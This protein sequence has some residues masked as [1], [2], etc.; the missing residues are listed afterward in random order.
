MT[1]PHKLASDW[2]NCNLESKPYLFP[3]DAPHM[4]SGNFKIFQSFSEY[5]SSK[6]FGLSPDI[7]LHTG[8]LPIPYAGNLEKASI[9]VL[10]LNPGLSA[11]DYFAEQQPE[12]RNAQ[13][14]NLRQENGSIEYPFV[15]LNPQFAWHPGFGY[16]HK[17]FGAVIE[18]LANQSEITYQEAMSILSK[19]LA[20]LELLPYHSKSFG[21]GSLLKILPSVKVMQ[22]FVHEV[23]IPKAKDGK[24]IIIATRG[25]KNWQL[26]KHKNIIAYEGGETR[27][28][29]LSPS[30]RGGMAI[31]NHLS[32]LK[33]KGG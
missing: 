6:E 2:R 25:V 30:S 15:F 20:C 7:K 22:N 5:V 33:Q 21:S 8:L 10:M 27:S 19:N 29:H 1:L 16:W 31:A 18:K 26:P 3:D 4:T 13:I 32:L 24:V 17:K 11:G 28:A 12:F 23:L 9:F 14:Q